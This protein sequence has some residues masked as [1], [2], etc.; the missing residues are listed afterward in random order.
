M[1][2]VALAAA[3][4]TCAA[5]AGVATAGV[6]TASGQPGIRAPALTTAERRAITISSV[7]AVGDRSLGLIV[8][9]TFKGDIQGHLGRGGL[10]DGLLALVFVPT[11]TA[12]ASNPTSAART[13]NPTSAARASNG[14]IDSV[15][16]NGQERVL[17]RMPGDQI[18]VIRSHN[19]VIFYVAGADLGA[20]AKLRVEVFARRPGPQKQSASGAS[21]LVWSQ[22][23]KARPTARATLVIDPRSITGVQLQGLRKQLSSIVSGGLEPELRGQERARARLNAAIGHYAR[24]APL[25]GRS[26]GLSKLG[27]AAVIDDLTRTGLIEDLTMT[28]LTIDRLDSEIADL[29]R[30]LARAQALLVASRMPPAVQVVQTDPRLSQYLAPQPGLQMSPDPP[31]RGAL[32]DV[33]EGVHYQRFSGLGAA[34]TDSSAWLIYDQ[35]SPADRLALLQALFG[36][37]GLPNPLG[38]PPIHLNFLRVAIGASGAMTVGAPYSYDDMPPGRSDPNLAGFS[39]AHDL[40]YMLPTLQQALAVNPGLEILASPWSPPG[41]MKSNDSL[42][43]IGANGRLLSSAHGPLARYIVKF[44]QAYQSNGV[45]IDAITPENE[46]SSGQVSTAYPG[47]T[48][49]EPDEAQLISHD[50]RPALRAAGLDTKIFGD[51]FGWDSMDYATS[52]TSGP[53]AGDLSGLAWHCYFGSPNVMS[54]LH[55]TALGLD[56]IVDECSPEIRPFGTPEFLISSLRNWASAAA[57][58]SVA[59]DPSGGPIQ[60]GN[61]CPGCTGPVTIDEQT[62]KVTFRPVYYQLGQ[63]SAFVQP[64]AVRIDSQNFGSYAVD[65]SNF[66]TVAAGLDDVAFLNPDGSKVLVAY[67]NS[68]EPISFGV[69]SAGRY[70]TYKIPARAMTTFQWDPA[71]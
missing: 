18:G 29:R 67:N 13:S 40:A 47:M 19:K 35:L 65:S 50:L 24:T 4:C 32:I 69:E 59:L 71:R 64:G 62:H 70:F 17:N 16:T 39:I 38:A 51:D 22:L 6:V 14:L 31:D 23:L 44:I 46:P 20:I 26:L 58:W 2:V 11:S 21:P 57:V 41:W 5:L 27:K 10:S 56:Q 36:A 34:M 54:Q 3:S 49:P 55:Q 9:T 43:N 25:V 48:L 53:A 66:E 12:R 61:N 63:V 28:A 15:D 8:T 30:L 37:A 33:D 52:L 60:P 7:R 68:G 42:D 45:P 1:L